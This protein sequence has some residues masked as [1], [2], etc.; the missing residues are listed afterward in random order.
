MELAKPFYDVGVFSNQSQAQLQFWQQQVGLAFDHSLKLGGGVLQH[1]HHAAGAVLKLNDARDPLPLAL[2]GPID[3]LLVA[4]EKVHEPQ[5]LS[6]PDGN[7]VRLVPPGYRGIQG[8]AV[9]LK[10]QDLAR[11]E[12]FYCQVLGLQPVEPGLL[13]CGDTRLL[14][15]AGAAGV[16]LAAPLAATGVRYITLQ[17]FDCDATYAKALAGGATSGREPVTLGSTARIAFIRDPDG[18]WIELSERASVTGK[19]V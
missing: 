18:T 11:S 19:A 2:D 13:A 14:L 17:V 5:L 10:V 16:D 3:E 6:D 9:Q 1:R 4:S 7:P 8:L 12:E 15:S